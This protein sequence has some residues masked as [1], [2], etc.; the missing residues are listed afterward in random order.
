MSTRN[1]VV[2]GQVKGQL[3]LP[4]ST[5]EQEW[6]EKL[7]AY[8]PVVHVPTEVTPRQIKQALIL[9]GISMTDVETAL[10]SLSEPTKSLAKIEWEYSLAFQ[11][12]RPLVAQ[13]G[14]MLGWTSQQLD[15]LWVFASKL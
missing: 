6:A 4:D 5:S 11:R 8:T 14:Q 13:V 1:I 3:T 2:N 12:N 15:D 7:A 9:S 10:D